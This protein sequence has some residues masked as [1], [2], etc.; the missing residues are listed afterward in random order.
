MTELTPEMVKFESWLGLTKREADRDDKEGYST[1][2]ISIPWLKAL[3]AAFESAVADAKNARHERD[4]FALA[5]QELRKRVEELELEFGIKA[6]CLACGRIVD[7]DSE[8]FAEKWK[9]D[10][11]DDYLCP[12]C[13]AQAL[14]DAGKEAGK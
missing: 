8:E 1:L 2:Q 12:K 4:V 9:L 13:A 3:L 6:K 7:M 10:A 14:R 11:S 5:E